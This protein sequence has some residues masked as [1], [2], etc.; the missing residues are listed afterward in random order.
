MSE[1]EG[2]LWVA[3]DRETINNNYKYTANM[4]P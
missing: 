1:G 2:H 3:D 4:S